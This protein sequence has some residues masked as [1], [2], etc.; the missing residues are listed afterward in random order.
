MPSTLY[1][2][3]SL[4]TFKDHTMPYEKSKPLCAGVLA[5]LYYIRAW[6]MQNHLK[7]CRIVYCSQYKYPFLIGHQ[8]KL[9]LAV[10]KLSEVQR[11][12]QQARV[13]SS[14]ISTVEQRQPPNILTIG[15]Q[16]SI[17]TASPGDTCHSPRATKLTS[18]QD[19]ELSSEL[20]T[21]MISAYANTNNDRSNRVIQKSTNLVRQTSETIAYNRR[22]LSLRLQRTGNVQ[23]GNGLRN[24]SLE[25]LE[26]ISSTQQENGKS[27]MAQNMRYNSLPRGP[28]RDGRAGSIQACLQGCTAPAV[29]PKPRPLQQ[30]RSLPS[31][32]AATLSAFSPPHT[33]TKKV[34]SSPTPAAILPEYT[35]YHGV[36]VA[37]ATFVFPNPVSKFSKVKVGDAMH[38]VVYPQ[39]DPPHSPLNC[40][41]PCSHDGSGPTTQL[42]YIL[43]QRQLSET[44]SPVVVSV[45]T[46]SS[47]SS[48][49]SAP[50]LKKRSHSLNR[51][52]T[53]S[54]GEAEDQHTLSYNASMD[55]RSAGGEGNVNLGG[56]SKSPGT[57]AYATMGRRVGRSH[58]V[59]NR[60][61]LEERGVNRS[62]SF[63]IRQKRRGPPP[64]PPKRSSSTVSTGTGQEDAITTT[65][66]NNNMTIVTSTNTMTNSAT[67][68]VVRIPSMDDNMNKYL[69]ND[70]RSP[71]SVRSIAAMLEK[72]GLGGQAVF[73]LG[74][75]GNAAY[76]GVTTSSI[77]L[78][79]RP[80]A[81]TT[82]GS[83]NIMDREGFTTDE[84][85]DFEF[86]ACF[87]QDRESSIR[88]NE[89]AS[90]LRA[91]CNVQEHGTESLITCDDLVVEQANHDETELKDIE[92]ELDKLERPPSQASSTETIPFA[93]EGNLTIKQRPRGVC[94]P[95]KEAEDVT[96]EG[97]LREDE[98]RNTQE[99]PSE[100][101]PANAV[102]K[103]PTNL[104]LCPSEVH[105]NLTESGTVK[106]RP[107]G[108]EISPQKVLT[109]NSAYQNLQKDSRQQSLSQPRERD[110]AT[111]AL[112]GSGREKPAISPKPVFVSLGQQGPLAITK[113][114]LVLSAT[115]LGE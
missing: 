108:K 86:S 36:T 56:S 5:D 69:H 93:E 3:T 89:T 62:Q 37:P 8:K 22:D 11:A 18:F 53:S 87:I 52:R 30:Q 28:T 64:P 66:R 59:R 21:A 25:S 101:Q 33:P 34:S 29:P 31:Q 39:P 94:S 19:S 84:S 65:D 40:Q 41:Q 63:V 78:G 61:G 43:P 7:F 32:A 51:R 114:P 92:E 26:R 49:D 97:S 45:P 79:S 16:E 58:S 100:H 99:G 70:L 20:Q 88:K 55:I 38:R 2:S 102:T 75:P 82:T 73:N 44:Q 46:A 98:C 113:K 95:M 76:D 111:S 90:W 81:T 83:S 17:D 35:Q 4:C 103:N 48:S 50:T 1:V 109:Q 105:L 72:S 112:P 74:T 10:R 15:P 54:D 77:H 24:A 14:V 85:D 96:P 13:E 115:A 107:K 42:S 23:P 106:R 68:N 57:S 110:R 80:L 67:S 6:V 91:N 71:L 9:M 12:E 60:T 47:L 104:Q 27:G